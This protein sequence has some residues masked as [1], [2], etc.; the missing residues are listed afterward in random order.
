MKKLSL[1]LITSLTL[2]SCD[3]LEGKKDGVSVA[4]VNNTYLYEA[5]IASL[6][7]SSISKEDSA[8]LV[9]SFINQWATEEL[10]MNQAIINISEEQQKNYNKL[11]RQYKVS[12]FTE[13]YKN[14]L[15]SRDLDSII[16]QDE[17]DNLYDKDKV[18][19]LLNDELLK[20]RYVHLDTDNANVTK[21]K[22][23]LKNYTDKDKATLSTMNLQF[24]AVNLNDSVWVKKEALLS[25]LPIVDK[26][27]VDLTF[28]RF[29][30]IKDSTGI[31]IYK[32][33]AKLNKGDV[34]PSSFIAPTLRQIILNKRKLELIRNIE[35]DITKDAIKN[36]NFEIYTKE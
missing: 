19:F 25:V 3:L 30:E 6:V 1:F 28:G 33:V 17:L 24:K 14:T 27:E 23:L 34:T 21:I 36:N 29:N 5:D 11:V 31:Y 35:K 16:S 18:N 15:V 32:V 9:S 12:L 26:N 2:I 4:K 7:D 10:L 20:I 13:A 8:I 22:K